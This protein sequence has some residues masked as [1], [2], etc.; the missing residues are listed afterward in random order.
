MID[1]PPRT[2]TDISASGEPSVVAI[3]TP[4][5][6]PEMASR[7]DET[8]AAAITSALTVPTAPVKSFFLT[9]P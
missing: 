5:T 2:L 1:V 6:R 9:E 8:G 7:A 4:A 3:W